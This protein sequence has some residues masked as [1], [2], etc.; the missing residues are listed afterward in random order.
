MFD[1]NVHYI[2]T[3]MNHQK[4]PFYCLNYFRSMMPTAVPRQ[5]IKA[6]S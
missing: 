5:E 2:H 3:N 4:K 6:I 1:C